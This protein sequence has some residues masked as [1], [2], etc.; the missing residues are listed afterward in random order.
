MGLF[1]HCISKALQW[2]NI[3]EYPGATSVG[4]HNQVMLAGVDTQIANGG[5]WEVVA[6]RMPVV[7]AVP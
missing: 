4:T 2:T 1:T 6:D 5:R 3:V 7:A